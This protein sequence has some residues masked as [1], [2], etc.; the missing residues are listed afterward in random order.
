M[1]ELN[2]YKGAY[3]TKSFYSYGRALENCFNCSYCRVFSDDEP[4]VY[5]ELPT[6]LNPMFRYFPVAVN[7]MYGDPDRKS[8]V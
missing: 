7:L 4:S 5:E 3:F 6:D 1:E 2:L 8:V